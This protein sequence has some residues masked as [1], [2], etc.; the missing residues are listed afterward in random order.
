MLVTINLKDS[1][2][3]VVSLFLQRADLIGLIISLG[4]V[5]LILKN[6]HFNMTGT[7]EIKDNSAMCSAVLLW[8][9]KACLILNCSSFSLVKSNRFLN[10]FASSFEKEESNPTLTDFYGHLPR[11]IPNSLAWAVLPIASLFFLNETHLWWL[12]AG[13]SNRRNFWWSYPSPSWCTR[14]CSWNGHERQISWPWRFS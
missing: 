9:C 14:K 7:W 3:F 13:W 12:R 2:N 11:A 10:A 6:S 8:P 1:S 5:L 4:N